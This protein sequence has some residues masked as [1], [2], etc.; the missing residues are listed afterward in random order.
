MY[1][2][3]EKIMGINKIKMIFEYELVTNFKVDSEKIIVK[4]PIKKTNI[5]NFE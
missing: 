4:K 3:K 2:I 1:K 5:L